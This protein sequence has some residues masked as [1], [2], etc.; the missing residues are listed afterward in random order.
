MAKR[1]SYIDTK[2]CPTLYKTVNFYF[3]QKV[4]QN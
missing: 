3:I 1:Y 2:K 4:K